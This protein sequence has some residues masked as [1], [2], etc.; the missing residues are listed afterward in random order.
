VKVIDAGWDDGIDWA[1]ALR[2]QERS[3]RALLG[4]FDRQIRDAFQEAA[5]PFGGALDTLLR[6]GTRTLHLALGSHFGAELD[7]L[8]DAVD[9]EVEDLIVANLAYDLS[10]AVGCSTFVAAGKAGLI[11]ARTVDWPFPGQLLRTHTTAVRVHGAPA[12]QYALVGWPGFFGA[13]TGVAPGRFSVTVNYVAHAT[14]SS[15]GPALK[16]AVGGYWPVPWAVRLALDECRTFVEAV[17]YLSEVPLLSP[18][19][20]TVAGKNR[21]EAV[22]IERGPNDFFQR[23]RNDG[24]ACTANHYVSNVYESENVELEETSSI[25]RYE[26]LDRRLGRSA[27]MTAAEALKEFSKGS[28]NDAS[29]QHR[30]VMSAA[31]RLLVVQVPGR[32]AVS[33][34][35]RS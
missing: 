28:V 33:V 10:H 14:E 2:G 13:L 3:A 35:L 11:H 1:S 6:K 19:L 9:V 23:R 20:F 31:E 22:T 12:G 8:A 18:V 27:S 15:L 16:R 4:G 24:L 29:T 17:R 25:E 34:P 30:V 7:S 21:G 26:Q 5:G 32:K